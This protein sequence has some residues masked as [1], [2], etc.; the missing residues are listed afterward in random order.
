MRRN[1]VAVEIRPDRQFCVRGRVGALDTP[2][3][4]IATPRHCFTPRRRRAEWR[5]TRKGGTRRTE[6]RKVEQVNTRLLPSRQA[7]LPRTRRTGSRAAAQL[8][9][10]S[11]RERLDRGQALFGLVTKERVEERELL[12]RG[13]GNDLRTAPHSSTLLAYRGEQDISRA[14]TTRRRT[15]LRLTGSNPGKTCSWYD[16]FIARICSR[17]GVP[18]ILMMA[19]SWSMPLVP[20]KSTSPMMSSAR[21]QPTD[22]MSIATAARTFQVSS[23]RPD[24][25]ESR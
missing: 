3:W 1:E 22:H 12:G 17:V 20:A 24:M 19:T 11:V 4:L 23:V 14:L 13:A 21:M 15:L 7:Q 10:E 5:P 2:S 8:V 6:I 16:S 25:V 9:V 18:R